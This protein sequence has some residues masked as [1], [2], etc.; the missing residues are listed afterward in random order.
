MH[1]DQVYAFERAQPNN[2]NTRRWEINKTWRYDVQ[3]NENM[4][5]QAG[6]RTSVQLGNDI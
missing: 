2:S 3:V 5:A 6:L 4:A 1:H